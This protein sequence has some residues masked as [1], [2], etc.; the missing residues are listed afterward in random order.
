MSHQIFLLLEKDPLAMS[1]FSIQHCCKDHFDTRLKGW[2]PI[3]HSWKIRDQL[4]IKAKSWEPKQYLN[5]KSIHT[6]I[7]SNL[8]PLAPLGHKCYLYPS[9]CKYF[10]TMALPL[11]T[12][13]DR[14]IKVLSNNIHR[15]YRKYINWI[16]KVVAQVKQQY[17]LNSTIKA[18]SITSKVPMTNIK[19]K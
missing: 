16:L 3:W 15:C 10:M 18:K 12:I 19:S 14:C 13:D 11:L 2:W 17:R 5:Q 8:E 4:D 1:V 6:S 7:K 9:I